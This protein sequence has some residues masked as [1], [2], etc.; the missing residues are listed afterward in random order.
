MELVSVIISSSLSPPF[1]LTDCVW[2]SDCSRWHLVHVRGLQRS[3][4]TIMTQLITLLPNTS[5]LRAD[6]GGPVHPPFQLSEHYEY[7]W[8]SRS[9]NGSRD[10]F[11]I[12]NN[13]GHAFLRDVPSGD[14]SADAWRGTMDR[15]AYF[16]DLR[17]TFLV[18]KTPS[19]GAWPVPPQ[20]FAILMLRH[21]GKHLTHLL[22]EEREWKPVKEAR[23]CNHS[24]WKQS[25]LTSHRSRAAH[26]V[27]AWNA[28]VTEQQRSLR[29]AACWAV[30]RYEDL[31]AHPSLLYDVFRLGGLP[32]DALRIDG[33]GGHVDQP[34]I[35]DGGGR[36]RRL[37]AHAGNVTKGAHVVSAGGNDITLD[38]RFVFGDYIDDWLGTIGQVDLCMNDTACAA[39]LLQLEASLHAEYGY[40]LVDPQATVLH[41]RPLSRSLPCACG[42]VGPAG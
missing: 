6:R 5:G 13:E 40:R 22:Q 42:R 7:Q 32:V 26:G 19:R 39:E 23:Q 35:A 17:Q 1:G 30:L 38:P 11:Q 20:A 33:N 12:G 14:P 4:T 34:A 41:A 18:E 21:P 37:F 3:G 27:V 31:I 29:Q 24:Q 2:R 28:T 10:R 8:G 15:W 16:W 36:R 25:D 9:A